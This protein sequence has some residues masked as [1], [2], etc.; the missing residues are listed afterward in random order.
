[1]RKVWIHR[2]CDSK[3]HAYAEGV[4]DGSGWV[5]PSY[6]GTLHVLFSNEEEGRQ[7]QWLAYGDEGADEERAEALRLV[8]A[9]VRIPRAKLRGEDTWR[10]QRSSWCSPT[11]T[12][13]LVR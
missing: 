2:E 1:M 3:A 13:S 6:L 9:K 5:E 7:W 8:Q 11:A 12:T 10:L 4:D